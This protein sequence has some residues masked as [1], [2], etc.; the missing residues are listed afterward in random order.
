MPDGR[1]VVAA[2]VD[3]AGPYP[4]L[5]DTGS[6]VTILDEKLVEELGLAPL[7]IVVVHGVGGQIQAPA[8]EPVRIGVGGD[9]FEPRLV[10][11]LDLPA[12]SDARGVIGIDLLAQRIVQIDGGEARLRLTRGRYAP[13]ADRRYSRSRLAFDAHGLPHVQIRVNDVPGLALID[14]GLGGMILDPSFAERAR[15]PQAD[16]P[17]ELLDAVQEKS[18]ARHSGRARIEI[19]RA[20]WIVSSIALLR[21]SVLD[22]IDAGAPTEAIV[23]AGVFATSTMVIDFARGELFIVESR[24]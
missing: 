21:P 8:Y 1:L 17:I 20:R 4:F 9:T 16:G 12:A 24:A 3:G 11:A 15:V 19:G 2:T 7:R 10:V 18:A 23:G 5:V 6:T 14:T 22:K 13:P